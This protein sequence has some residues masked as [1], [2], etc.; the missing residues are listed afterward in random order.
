MATSSLPQLEERYVQEEI[1]AFRTEGFWTDQTIDSTLDHWAAIQPERVFMTDGYG[2]VTYG[3]L[4]GQGYRLAAE[5]R[6]LGIEPGDRVGVQLPNWWEFAVVAVAVARIGGIIVP[7][8][9]ILRSDEV[10]YLIEH[11]SMRAVVT[12]ETFKGFDYL[13]MYR[14]LR[15]ENP[16]LGSIITVRGS[17]HPD[18]LDLESLTK[19]ERGD[20]IPE[21]AALGPSPDAD[22][23]LLLVYTSGTESRP[24]GCLHTYNTMLFTS[25]TMHDLHSWTRKDVAFGPSPLAHS[26]GYNTSIL[27]PLLAG[28]SSHVMDSWDPIDGLERIR[29]FGCTMTTTA[30]VFLKMLIEAYRPDEHDASTMRAWIAAGS[31]IP[32]A[33][34]TAARKALPSCEVLSLY[35]RSENQVTTMCRVGEDPG[36]VT[37]S[38]GRAPAG[39]EIA[40][41]DQDGNLLA[42]GEIGDIAYRGPGHML[43]YLGAPDLTAAMF[44]NDGF[45]RSGDL[46][47][48]DDAG[49]VRVT[50]RA[51]DIII[52]GGWNISAREIEDHLLGHDDVSDIAV[53]AMP[54]EQ[55]GE[56]AC[57]FVVPAPGRTPTL[58]TLTA[59]LRH[60]RNIAVQKLPERL[61]IVDE[62]P[63]TPTGKVQKFV[64]RDLITDALASEG[65]SSK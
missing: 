31:P 54:D 46:G 24:K 38:D 9:P 11:A 45:S 14:E 41:V 23:G 26:T 44:T 4:R 8:M 37:S 12:A 48:M 42:S 29:T 40:I 13:E 18:T 21:L 55:L 58:E 25:R 60:D 52:R 49:Y 1:A 57:A 15:A 3:D 34:V 65:A 19:P 2:S 33:V 10:R 6:R 5:L 36:R 32:E 27:I 39:V 62:L 51:K 17:D 63:T 20:D 28:A 56:R 16:A 35:G 7:V 64:L 53:V 43:G 59:F 61:E 47:R 50:G 22:D 30:T